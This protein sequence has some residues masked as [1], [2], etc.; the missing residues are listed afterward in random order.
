M[1][2]RVATAPVFRCFSAAQK[3]DHCQPRVPAGSAGC[4]SASTWSSSVFSLLG[5]KSFSG[6]HMLLCAPKV[7]L[8]VCPF[9]GRACPWCCASQMLAIALTA[10]MLCASSQVNKGLVLN[11]VI[12]MCAQEVQAVSVLLSGRARRRA[13]AE[14]KSCN[15]F[16]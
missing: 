7:L 6:A 1:G 8:V 12:C 2:S 10:G 3:C 13:D 16:Q 11:I 9:K 15:I 14:P 4:F 5:M